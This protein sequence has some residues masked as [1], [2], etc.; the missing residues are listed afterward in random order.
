MAAMKLPEQLN[1]LIRVP[2]LTWPRMVLAVMVAGGAD[3]LQL[4]LAEFGWLGL[5]QVIDGVAMVLLTCILGFHVLFLPTFV[6]ELIP[7]VEDLPTWTACTAAVIV[8]RKREQRR[9]PPPPAPRSRP[10]I[11]I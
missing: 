2:R 3:G 9:P 5:D 8:L 6:V 7:V 10:A 11:D 1:W 4:I